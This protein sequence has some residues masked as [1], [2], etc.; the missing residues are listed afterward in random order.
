MTVNE[1]LCE[2]DELKPSKFDDGLMIQWLTR[3]EKKIYEEII[4]THE[5]EDTEDEEK[6]DVPEQLEMDYELVVPDTYADLYKYYVFSM[7]DFANTEFDLYGNSMA[8]FNQ[9]YQE[10][11][12][13]YNR[14]HRVKSKPLIVL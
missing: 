4:N 6:W 13:Y 10:F 5:H 1:V 2:V 7:I 12:N 14:T 3:L 9:S 11:C 8:M